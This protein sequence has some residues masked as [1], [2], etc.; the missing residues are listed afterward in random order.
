MAKELGLPVIFHSREA[1][2]ETLRV[3]Q[4]EKAW[5]VGGAMHYFQGTEPTARRCLELGFCISLAKPLMR[6]PHL[7]EL[8][9]SLPREGI[10]LESDCY[11]Q[12]F[13]KR[14]ENWTEPRH[15]RLVAE[16]LSQLW[17]T[18]LEDVAAITT[19]NLGKL[20]NRRALWTVSG[21]G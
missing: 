21:P 8:V 13:K 12:P 11:P 20:L 18:S 7:Q 1:D 16:K 19:G 17:G 4:E 6:L 14:R 5:E 9:K 3:L 2:Q 15:V 10:I